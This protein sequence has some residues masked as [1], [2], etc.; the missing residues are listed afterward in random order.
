M[1]MSDF[2]KE[3]MPLL[4]TLISMDYSPDPMPCCELASN[5]SGSMTADEH[6]RM[7]IS[8]SFEGLDLSL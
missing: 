7:I 4:A 3:M 8:R 6:R 5:H 1:K 2:I